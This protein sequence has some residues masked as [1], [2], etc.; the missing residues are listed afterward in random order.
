M[1][2]NYIPVQCHYLIVTDGMTAATINC[3]TGSINNSGHQFLKCRATEIRILAFTTRKNNLN[4]SC[5]REV[6]HFNLQ[7]SAN[8]IETNA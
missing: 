2:Q 4:Q 8:G 7:S 6:I 5:Q 1:L 3:P